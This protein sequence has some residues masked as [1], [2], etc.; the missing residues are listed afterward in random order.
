MKSGEQPELQVEAPQSFDSGMGD[1]QQSQCIQA[2]ND[3]WVVRAGHTQNLQAGKS[4][5]AC[6]QTTRT[7]SYVK[8]RVFDTNGFN[9]LGLKMGTNTPMGNLIPHTYE[10]WGILEHTVRILFEG[11]RLQMNET[12]STVGESTPRFEWDLLGKATQTNTGIL[13]RYSR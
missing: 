6:P 7:P 11:A 3:V 4:I 1:R 8:I 2:D 5:A 13:V 12:L 9:E 10:R